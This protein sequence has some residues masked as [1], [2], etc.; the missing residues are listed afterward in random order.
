MADLREQ[1]LQFANH[2]RNPDRFP[3]PQGIEERRLLVYR[4]LFFNNIS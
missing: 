3:A 4:D 1:Q 2:L